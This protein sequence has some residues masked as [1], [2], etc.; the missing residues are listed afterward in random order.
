MVTKRTWTRSTTCQISHIIH[1][2]QVICI[3]SVN[4]LDDNW[5]LYM[6][7]TKRT[8]IRSITCKLS[9]IIDLI[10]LICI[11]ILHSLKY[12]NQ[13]IA[14][15]KLRFKLTTKTYVPSVTTILISSR[16]NTG[17]LL[18]STLTDTRHIPIQKS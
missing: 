13:Q 11:I 10:K 18:L 1:H 7:I 4:S 3:T 9:H 12:R 14:H 8:S 5:I 17:N 2:V 16:T 6:K 15:M